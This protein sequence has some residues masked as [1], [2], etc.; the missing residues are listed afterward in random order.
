MGKT[1]NAKAFLDKLVPS[2]ITALELNRDR[3]TFLQAKAEE[4]TSDLIKMSYLAEAAGLLQANVHIHEQFEK[5]G[6]VI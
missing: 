1:D 3:A 2:L 6:V 4:C 5:D